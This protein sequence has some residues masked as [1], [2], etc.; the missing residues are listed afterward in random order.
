MVKKLINYSK[1][2]MINLHYLVAYVDCSQIRVDEPN[3]INLIKL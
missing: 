1:T 2:V 3:P